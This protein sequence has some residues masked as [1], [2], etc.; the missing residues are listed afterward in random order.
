MVVVP[1]DDVPLLLLVA[2]VAVAVATLRCSVTRIPFAVVAALLLL[3]PAVTHENGL[4][5]VNII[6]IVS[7]KSTVFVF[8]HVYVSYDFGHN[9]RQSPTRTNGV[10]K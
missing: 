10:Y 8:Q 6:L 3:P 9:C 4:C 7:F 1:T 2:V 5:S